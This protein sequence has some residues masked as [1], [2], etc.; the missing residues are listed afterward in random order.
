MHD[1]CRVLA[2]D[3]IVED[4][5]SLRM[6][7]HDLGDKAIFF[8]TRHRS[9]FGKLQHGRHRYSSLRGLQ[10]FWGTLAMPTQNGG[11]DTLRLA[12]LARS[13]LSSAGLYSGLVF[14]LTAPSFW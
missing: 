7:G 13:Q 3:H 4:F 12:N 1:S 6:A 14:L 5:R 8:L 9:M 2:L 10:E 11:P